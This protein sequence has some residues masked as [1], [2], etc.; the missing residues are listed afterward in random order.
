MLLPS[1]VL[2]WTCFNRTVDILSSSVW[3][4]LAVEMVPVSLWSELEN[5]EFFVAVDGASELVSETTPSKLGTGRTVG[6]ILDV[7]CVA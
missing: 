5:A 4:A 3:L 6:S 1:D 7:V 2:D